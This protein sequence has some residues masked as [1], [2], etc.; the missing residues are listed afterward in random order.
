M[1]GVFKVCSLEKIG[2]IQQ[3]FDVGVVRVSGALLR[4]LGTRN[5][6]VR[7]SVLENGKPQKS[8]VR[9]I[10]AA[11]GTKALRKDEIALQYDDRSE[12]GIKKAGTCHSISIEPIGQWWGLPSFLLSHTSPLVRRDAF[13]A[14]GLATL[15]ALLGAI[16]GFGIGRIF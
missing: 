2:T 6:M 13:F 10:R 8:L 12:L 14:L 7:V 1:R 16:V 5:S 3:D 15:S 9:I 4:Q 11:T